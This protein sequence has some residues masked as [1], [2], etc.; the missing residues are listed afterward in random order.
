MRIHQNGERSQQLIDLKFEDGRAYGRIV[1]DAAW[2]EIDE[3]ADLFA[4]GGD[5][6]GF[7]TATQSV[8]ILAAGEGDDLIFDKLLPGEQS[9]GL[10]R[11]VF[12]LDGL[13]YAQ[14]LRNQTEEFLRRRG[15]WRATCIL[16]WRAPISI[17]QAA[18]NCGSPQ[19]ACL[20]DC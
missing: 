4:P 8:R 7:L 18:A 3:R 17:W 9:A 15:S 5:L 1:A 16:R 6:L 2:T 10:T 11:Y 14:Y 13:H 12:A 19:T 20:C